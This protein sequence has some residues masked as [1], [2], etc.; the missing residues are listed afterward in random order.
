MHDVFMRECK[1]LIDCR[2]KG[3]SLGEVEVAGPDAGGAERLERPPGADSAGNVP[4][5]VSRKSPV[6]NHIGE[7]GKTTKLPSDA[8]QRRIENARALLRAQSI[9][10]DKK[11]V[12]GSLKKSALGVG[13]VGETG[14]RGATGSIGATGT[15]GSIGATSATGAIGA[16][17]PAG[18]EPSTHVITTLNS[19]ISRLEKALKVP[20]FV[21][22][23]KN[24]ADAR[25]LF[26]GLYGAFQPPGSFS[27]NGQTHGRTTHDSRY[28][29]IDDDALLLLEHHLTTGYTHGEHGGQN[30]A[31]PD[32]GAGGV[33]S[34]NSGKIQTRAIVSD[35]KGVVS[36]TVPLAEVVGREDSMQG[37][38]RENPKQG[39]WGGHHESRQFQWAPN[40]VQSRVLHPGLGNRGREYQPPVLR[41]TALQPHLPAPCPKPSGARGAVPGPGD[42]NDMVDTYIDANKPPLA[43]IA[44]AQR[45]PQFQDRT[46]PPFANTVLVEDQHAD[47]QFMRS[48]KTSIPDPD[49]VPDGF[50]NTLKNAFGMERC[51][52]RVPATANL[53]GASFGLL[54]AP[55]RALKQQ[56]VGYDLRV[57]KMTAHARDA[58]NTPNTRRRL[59]STASNA[60]KVERR[61]VPRGSD[62][63]PLPGAFPPPPRL[64][65]MSSPGI[66]GNNQPTT[67]TLKEQD[68]PGFLTN[69][70]ALFSMPTGGVD[71]GTDAAAEMENIFD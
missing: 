42:I 22:R 12:G 35:D 24:N 2:A 9:A 52:L 23:L 4:N 28:H 45:A 14:A 19:R 20:K 30:F 57:P 17:G 5:K 44:N 70:I 66:A 33:T 21:D 26:S 16:T 40:G 1:A 71:V 3:S 49:G 61:K 34:G 36:I 59:E 55:V 10:N 32:G 27:T 60:G 54:R 41:R 50:G 13:P 63:E 53:R 67:Q 47:T 39:Q 11:T 25:A 58:P 43:I 48:N 62:S 7:T 46:S 65:R 37:A 51:D 18:T 68:L 64:L 15:T 6:G 38:G 8:S 56:H 69:E 31:T 29:D